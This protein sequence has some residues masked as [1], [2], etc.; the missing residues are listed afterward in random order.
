MLKIKDRVVHKEY[1]TIEGTVVAKT[2]AWR[3][4]SRFFLVRWDLGRAT[5]F[6]IQAALIYVVH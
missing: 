1:P 3:G 5:S 6:D 4:S 2:Q